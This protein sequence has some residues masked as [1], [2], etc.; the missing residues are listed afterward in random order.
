MNCRDVGFQYRRPPENPKPHLSSAVAGVGGVVA[1]SAAFATTKETSDTL[2]EIGQSTCGAP[3]A[4]CGIVA[5]AFETVSDHDSIYNAKVDSTTAAVLGA[6]GSV[7][8]HD[9]HST[10][11]TKIGDGVKVTANNVDITASNASHKYW[12]GQTTDSNSVAVA[13]NAAWNVNAGSGGLFSLPAAKTNAKIWHKTDVALGQSSLFHILLPVSGTGSFNVDALNTIVA[14]DKVKIDS[15]GAIALAEA[16][17]RLNVTKNDARV[18]LGANSVVSSD[19][20]DINI[21]SRAD[22]KLDARAA[23]NAYGL[24]GAPAGKAYINYTGD[25]TTEILGGA[26]LLAA[27]ASHGAI[28]V[29]AGDDSQQRASRIDAH[30]AVNLWNKTAVPINT[31]P[32][33]RTNVAQNATVTVAATSNVL[34][35]G[36]IGL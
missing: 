9:V 36:D 3:S 27:D 30:S 17:T 25:S 22:V 6:S 18:S 11:A 1:G 14:Y 5:G 34:A 23:A 8:D 21:G 16:D 32:D 2:A 19:S 10:V 31:T 4:T 20:G 29:S 7:T 12:W 28:N 33:A 24:A 13:D 26:L 15:G 35:A